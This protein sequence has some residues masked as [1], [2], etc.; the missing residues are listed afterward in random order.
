MFRKF[1]IVGT[2]A[3]AL[4]ACG[5][6]SAS[7]DAPAPTVSAPASAPAS[8][9]PESTA[10]GTAAPQAIVSMSATATEILYALDAADQVIAVDNYSN[11]PAEAADKMVGLDAFQPS[12][13]E[14]AALEP[15]LVITD[16]TNADFLGQLDELEIAHWEGEAAVTLDDVYT[17]IEELGAAI[18][19]TGEAEQ[20]VLGVRTRVDEAIA[21]L[22][23]LD[24]PL[25]YYHE[26]DDT[27]YSAT[28]DTFIGAVYAELGLVNIAD[29]AGADSPYPQ[30]SA[31]F[32]ID[33][34]PDLIFLAC[35]KYCTDVTAE[36]VGAR[37]GWEGISAV[38]SGGVIEMDDDI[39]S[40]WGPRI[41]DYIELVGEAVAAQADLQPAG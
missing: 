41:A 6:D 27:Y 17:Q 11:Y 23:E 25:T 2:L 38:V 40:R 4:A 10:P 36:S 22:P 12:V 8:T 1:L 9:T 31:E 29:E 33:A 15:D 32:I 26:L 30:L 21:G 14:I 19:R 37:P 5:D 35:T 34:D 39:A 20:L 3:A 7:S 24:E 16:G 13:E 18:G 28:S